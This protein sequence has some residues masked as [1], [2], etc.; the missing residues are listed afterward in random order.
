MHIYVCAKHVADT[1]ATISII[2]EKAFD[3]SI[4]FVINPYD[5][6]A[7]EEA[8]RIVENQG[9]EVIV[10]TV[11]KESAVHT[12][13]AALAVGAD[14]G[15]H[16][17]TDAQFVD[18]TLTSLALR[19]AIEMDGSPDLIFTGKQSEVVPVLTEVLKG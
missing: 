15:I 8:V 13:R 6:Y 11:G 4:K 17:K 19:K 9:G 18:A 2:G 5:E 3:E 1:A 14:R 7:L 12:V 10:V 16:V